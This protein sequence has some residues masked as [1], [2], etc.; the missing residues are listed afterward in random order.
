M[1]RVPAAAGEA[2]TLW[3]EFMLDKMSFNL[4]TFGL[5]LMAI[6]LAACTESTTPATPANNKA[7]GL[8]VAD[9][10]RQFLEIETVGSGAGALGGI[11]PGRVAFRPQAMA[12]IGTPMAAR[13]LSIEVR[14]GEAVKAGAPLLTLQSADVA[15]ARSS[16]DQASARA[17][18][19][20]DLLQR[21]NE[22]VKKGVGLEVERFGAETAAREA[23]AELERARR[24][25][26]LIG[27]G[28][29]DR[30]VLRAPTSGVV[31]TVKANVGAVVSPGGDALVEIGDPSRLW[32]VADIPENE[33]GSVAIG[34]S[35]EVRVP[36]ADAKFDAVVDGVGQV[37]DGEQRRLPMYLTLKGGSKRLTPGMLAEVRLNNQGDAILSVPTTAVLIKDGSQRVVYVQ[38]ADGKFEP[39]PVRTGVSRDGRVTILEGL[40]AGEKV[41][42]KGALLL[43]SAAEQLL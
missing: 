25:A 17:A 31:L 34:R 20:E 6:C 32:I 13:I 40:Q 41:V 14:P 37:V 12:A 19:A 21:Q 1:V 5:S 23:R 33:V 2:V 42:A 10:S 36:G 8:A 24:T 15:A 16:L 3:M 43:D 39:R 4:R 35:A 7:D 30:F 18:A 26:A 9:A 11:L 38:R 28:S 29:G 27:G 22:M